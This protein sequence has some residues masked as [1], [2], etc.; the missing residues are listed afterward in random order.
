MA[1]LMS[2]VVY[3]Q[4]SYTPVLDSQRYENCVLVPPLR[5][6]YENYTYSV[7]SNVNIPQSRGSN[8]NIT[9]VEFECLPVLPES[10]SPNHKTLNKNPRRYLA[11]PNSYDNNNNTDSCS[12]IAKDSNKKSEADKKAAKSGQSLLR[13]SLRLSKKSMGSGAEKETFSKKKNK[14]RTSNKTMSV[15]SNDNGGFDSASP[16]PVLGVKDKLRFS[17]DKINLK[18]P[19]RWSSSDKLTHFATKA[20]QSKKTSRR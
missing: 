9:P 13:R 16:K 1:A 6:N 3:H 17:L 2:S 4:D 11:T 10:A 18:S 19:F 7:S 5:P 8:R 15:D 14:K 12:E 20:N